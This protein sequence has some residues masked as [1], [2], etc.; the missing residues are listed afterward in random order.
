MTKEERTNR[1]NYLFEQ[2]KNEEERLNRLFKESL[3]PLLSSQN[4]KLET[5]TAIWNWRQEL[6]V[7]VYLISKENPKD[8]LEIT[9]TFMNYSEDD[10]RKDKLTDSKKLQ[11]NY[12]TC[13]S[14]TRSTDNGLHIARALLVAQIWEH[15]YLFEELYNTEINWSQHEELSNI[16]NEE[17]REERDKRDEELRLQREEKQRKL[18]E[19]LQ[20]L[21][22]GDVLAKNTYYKENSNEIYYTYDT[23]IEKITNQFIYLNRYNN[24]IGWQKRMPKNMVAEYLLKHSKEERFIEVR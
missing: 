17:Q 4:C 14:Y 2:L 24:H 19:V 3:E 12:G 22:P 13:G 11:M 20:D 15:D 9:L 5:S 7:Y 6:M 16:L 21:K 10:W 18:D 8:R 1:K 23:K